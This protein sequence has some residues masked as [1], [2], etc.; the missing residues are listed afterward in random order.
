MWKQLEMLSRHPLR[1][2]GIFKG[3][4]RRPVMDSKRFGEVGVY[5][6]AKVS[7]HQSTH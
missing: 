7:K 3:L 6:V 2:F 4:D 1:L 5:L